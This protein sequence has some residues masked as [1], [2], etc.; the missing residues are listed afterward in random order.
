VSECVSEGGRERG[1]EKRE[2]TTSY[3]CT[4]T[5]SKEHTIQSVCL[6]DSEYA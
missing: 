5:A 6:Q 4:Q 3:A 2:G 1:R